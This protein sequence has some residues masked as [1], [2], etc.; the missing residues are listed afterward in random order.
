VA[1]QTPMCSWLNNIPD[2]NPRTGRIKGNLI[3]T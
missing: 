1:Y 3:N 2:F